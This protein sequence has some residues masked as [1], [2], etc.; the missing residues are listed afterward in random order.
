MVFVALLKNKMRLTSR[1]FKFKIPLNCTD[2]T[3]LPQNGIYKKQNTGTRL[4]KSMSSAHNILLK[5]TFNS[6]NDH[7][8][9]VHYLFTWG[10]PLINW[11]TMSKN[12]GSVQERTCAGSSL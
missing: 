3:T 11:Y 6:P 10:L 2:G 5:N 9:F 8:Y 4:N 1:H 7:E 12:T